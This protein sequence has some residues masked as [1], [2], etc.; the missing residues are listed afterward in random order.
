MYIVAAVGQI[1]PKIV[2][3]QVHAGLVLPVVF[4]AMSVCVSPYSMRDDF[5]TIDCRT[6]NVKPFALC[7]EGFFIPNL[8]LMIEKGQQ[9]TD[10]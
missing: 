2:V 8:S 3:C 9:T 6:Y 7:A 4:L 1:R 5:P 10:N